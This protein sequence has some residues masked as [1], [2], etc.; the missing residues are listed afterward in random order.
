ML[1][2]LQAEGS[3]TMGMGHARPRVEPP[4]L[5]NLFDP[6]TYQP[7]FPHAVFKRLRAEAPVY[8]QEIPG[9]TEGRGGY[10]ARRAPTWSARGS[11][12]TYSP[13]TRSVR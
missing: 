3:T 11:P 12:A 9:W 5:V 1:S 8:W 10:C 13:T 6:D 4:Q 7:G 2:G